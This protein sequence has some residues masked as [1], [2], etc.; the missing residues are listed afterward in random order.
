MLS[1]RIFLSINISFAG[2]LLLLVEKN[3]VWSTCARLQIK[4]LFRV[5]IAVEQI[6]L[7]FSR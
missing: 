5:K 4:F 7:I 3:L 1:S 6:V 2:R